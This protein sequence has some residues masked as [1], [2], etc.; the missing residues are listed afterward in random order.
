MKNMCPIYCFRILLNFLSLDSSSNDSSSAMVWLW[1]RSNSAW[2]R[3]K[4]NRRNFF[5]EPSS[6]PRASL[7]VFASLTHNEA[8]TDTKWDSVWAFVT[9]RSTAPATRSSVENSSAQNSVDNRS[10]LSRVSLFKMELAFFDRAASPSSSPFFAQSGLTYSLGGR[11]LGLIGLRSRSW[12]VDEW[13]RPMAVLSRSDE[14]LRCEGKPGLLVSLRACAKSRD[15]KP[16][17]EEPP[18]APDLSYR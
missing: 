5:V 15:P 9:M 13:D 4:S 1:S 18:P 12:P 2:H 3:S 16:A 7:G 8:Y 10:N 14:S 17:P 11:F 6:S